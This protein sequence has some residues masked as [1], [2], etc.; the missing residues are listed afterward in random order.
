MRTNNMATPSKSF[1]LCDEDRRLLSQIV[2]D[3]GLESEADA[4]R[5]LLIWYSQQQIPAPIQPAI[6]RLSD[7]DE[8]IDVFNHFIEALGTTARYV[9]VR[10]RPDDTPERMAE[11]SKWHAR[12]HETYLVLEDT[13]TQ[14]RLVRFGVMACKDFD[15]EK[16]RA[17][18]GLLERLSDALGDRVRTGTLDAEELAEAERRLQLYNELRRFLHACGINLRPSP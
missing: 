6:S 16:L 5:F 14:L 3:H 15:V 2:L 1:R 10:H 9:E 18:E 4:V 12:A 7:L 8:L 11:V 17:T 13:V